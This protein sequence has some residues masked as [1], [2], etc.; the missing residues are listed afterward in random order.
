MH[1][2]VLNCMDLFC[3]PSLELTLRPKFNSHS[4]NASQ[5]EAVI[6]F[7]SGTSGRAKVELLLMTRLSSL[8]ISTLHLHSFLGSV[9]DDQLKKYAKNL[10]PVA[11]HY[12]I[13][14]YLWT[15]SGVCDIALWHALC[16]GAVSNGHCA[17]VLLC[18]SRQCN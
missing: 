11:C 6:I 10:S 1:N 12:A 7:S 3:H 18:N 17:S 8:V 15:D 2:V 14:S 4:F 5:R 13:L 9:H 16:Y